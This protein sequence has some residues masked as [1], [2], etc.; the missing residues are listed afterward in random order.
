MA[1]GS[2]IIVEFGTLEIDKADKYEVWK[3]K[4]TNGLQEKYNW[5]EN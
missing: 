5:E 4:Q 3:W 1:A 2:D